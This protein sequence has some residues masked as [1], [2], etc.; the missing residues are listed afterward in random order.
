MYTD[1]AKRD[2]E[3]QVKLNTCGYRVIL[4]REN[5]RYSSDNEVHKIHT[6]NNANNSI[7]QYRICFNNTVFGPKTST[8]LQTTLAADPHLDDEQF[9]LL[10]LLL[11][12]QFNSIQFIYMLT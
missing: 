7:S 8:S 3:K 10:L 12:I 2:S 5:N 9:L 4:I 11:L 6:N 1:D